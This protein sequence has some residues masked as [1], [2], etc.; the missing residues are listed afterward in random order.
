MPESNSIE[1]KQEYTPDIKKEVVAFA[2][3]NGGVIHVGRDD[4]G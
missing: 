4:D 3:S 1:Y 2:N